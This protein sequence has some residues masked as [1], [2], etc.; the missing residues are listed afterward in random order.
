MVKAKEVLKINQELCLRCGGCVASYPGIFEYD[1]EG[2]IKVKQEAEL[3]LNEL[4]NIKG[5]CP[6]AAIIDNK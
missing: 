5:V 6:V 4:P 3:D 1:E 2:G